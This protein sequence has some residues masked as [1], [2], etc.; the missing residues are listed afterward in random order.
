M[1][2]RCQMNTSTFTNKSWKE[3]KM[4]NWKKR[5]INAFLL[6]IYTYLKQ[7]ALDPNPSIKSNANATKIMRIEI[8]QHNVKIIEMWA[9]HTWL[10]GMEMTLHT[11]PSI[12]TR[13]TQCQYVENSYRFAG[14]INKIGRKLTEKW[15]KQN[16]RLD[17]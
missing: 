11:A 14:D 9:K 10:N 2:Q 17:K 7:T 6:Q 13:H 3:Q 12:H 16:E 5:N 8:Q 15:H 1:V 4:S